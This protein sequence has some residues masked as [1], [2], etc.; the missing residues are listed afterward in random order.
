MCVCARHTLWQDIAPPEVLWN[1]KHVVNDD[2]GRTFLL[3]LVA[4]YPAQTRFR[5]SRGVLPFGAQQLDLCSSTRAGSSSGSGIPCRA[6]RR[7]SESVR[8]TQRLV[9]VPRAV[10][11]KL[12]SGAGG[13]VNDRAL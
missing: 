7:A 1:R 9:W 12:G 4:L 11:G 2:A 5:S 8:D 10:T 3:V 6:T 13:R